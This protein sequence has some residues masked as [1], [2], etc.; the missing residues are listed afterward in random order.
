MGIA[1]VT[2]RRA[3]DAKRAY[4]SFNDSTST[5]IVLLF[6]G[7]S[8]LTL[9]PPPCVVVE[10]IDGRE[11]HFYRCIDGNGTNRTVQL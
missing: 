5:A 4:Q 11:Y 2:L 9:S 6:D 10:A 8:R 3:S 1:L 7:D